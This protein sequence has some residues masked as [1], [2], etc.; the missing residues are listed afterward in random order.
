MIFHKVKVSVA[1][2]GIV[3]TVGLSSRAQS[4]DKTGFRLALPGHAGQISWEADGYRIVQ[5]SA[6]PNGKEIGLRGSDA[7]GRR[8][9][10]G[11]LFTVAGGGSLSSAK[12]RDGALNES[13]REN[14][15]FKVSRTSE[16]AHTGGVPVSVVEYSVPGEGGKP[17]YSVRAFAAAGDICGDLEFYSSDA[18]GEEDP[19]LRK[20]FESFQFHEGYH[21]DFK[22]TFFYAQVL[23]NT[24]QYGAAAPYFEQSLVELKEGNGFD[25]RTWKR[26]ATDQAGMSYGIAGDV[27]K[28]RAIFDKAIRED[29]DYPLYYYNL[30]CADA[31][32]KNLADTRKHLQQA[33]DRKANMLPGEKIPDPTQDVS[34]TPYKDNKE[35]WSFVESLRSKSQ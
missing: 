29:P 19:A 20:I 21:P 9:F 8:T 26:V 6:K 15:A 23:F 27:K 7:S 30:A 10:L 1:M 2:L 33:F 34:F 35:F 5:S 18:I 12:C 4:A 25:T 28:A 16:I 14:P 13:K 24:K 32:E 11:F 17:L 3:L 22:D 31:E